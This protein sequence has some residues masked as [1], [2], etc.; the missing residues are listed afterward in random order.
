MIILPVG[1]DYEAE[2]YPVVTFWLMGI[3]AVVFAGEFAAFL[4]GAGQDLFMTFGLVPGQPVLW[5]WITSLF[6]HDAPLPFHLIG[7]MV[8]L[9][10]FGSC[11]E[12]ILGRG[13]F[14][15]FYLGGGVIANMIQVMF[16]SELGKDIPIIG[17]SGAISACL[18]AFLM[19]LP[20]T[21]IN[22]RYLIF[23]FYSG[24]FWIKSWIVITIWFAM[25]FIGFIID[26]SN[27]AEG[28]GVALG[29]HVGGTLAGIVAMR[30]MRRDKMHPAAA[31]IPA[32]AGPVKVAAVPEIVDPLGHV[33]VYISIDGSQS[34]P[35]PQAAVRGMMELGSVPPYAYF[36][37]E[38]IN[39]WRPITEM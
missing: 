27:P 33:P 17:A 12:D 19:V 31:A 26:L 8:Y 38:D 10:L 9:F 6:M 11:V 20:K 3:N 39:E 15:A 7:N 25:D 32:K 35:F 13:K 1:V 30:F 2:R 29:A 18:G 23:F 22:F 36:W 34:G 37:R 5:A 21:G 28:G 16:T 24:T 4:S 14:L